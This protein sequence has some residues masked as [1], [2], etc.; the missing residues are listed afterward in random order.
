VHEGDQ[1]RRD[2][3]GRAEPRA[4]C[5]VFVSVA[6]VA[7]YRPA[8]PSEVKLKKSADALTI[9]LVRNPDILAE[10]ASRADAPF[11]VG[12][13]AE[14][15]DLDTYAQGKRVAKSLPLVVG[16]LV[17]DGLGGEDNQVVLYDAKGAI[18]WRR[19]PKASVARAILDHIS[20]QLKG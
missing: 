17:S 14:S 10:V 18:Q 1:R 12:F 11:C 7:D 4:D 13:A 16:N 3:R 2:A 5:D 8:R 20:R 19:A 9:D 15:H 6:A